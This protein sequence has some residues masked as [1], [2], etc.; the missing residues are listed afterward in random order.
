MLGDITSYWRA[1]G[2]FRALLTS[3]YLWF[4][5]GLTALLHPW[6]GS[7]GKWPDISLLILPPLLG[8]TIGAMAVVLAF[9]TSRIFKHI[10]ED[11][12]P[13]SYY[14]QLTSKLVH[15]IIIQTLGILVSLVRKAYIGFGLDIAGIFLLCYAMLTAIA[16]AFSL[17][18][19]SLLYNESANIQ[20][21]KKE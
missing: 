6:W 9:P 13:D 20:D 15:F 7:D 11:G 16:V 1:Y 14:A 5:V 8:F 2:G 3:P 19:I 4:A 12:R 10:A 17:F 21:D 18:N